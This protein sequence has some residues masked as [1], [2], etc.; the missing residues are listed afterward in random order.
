MCSF[1]RDDLQTLEDVDAWFAESPAS[2][3]VCVGGNHDFPLQRREFQFSHAEFLEDRLIEVEGLTIYGSPWCPDLVGFAYYLSDDD[4]AQRWRRIPEAIDVLITHTPPY[5]I[6][7]VHGS[8]QDS[9][10]R[11]L[12]CAIAGGRDFEVCHSPT[13]HSLTPM[14]K[15]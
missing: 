8:H 5:G 15:I 14:P 6:L 13:M 12:N 7:D 11:Y 9:H 1:H 10:T 2:H 4:L 3:V